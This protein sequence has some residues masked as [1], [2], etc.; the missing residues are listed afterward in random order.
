MLLHFAK[1]SPQEDRLGS[2]ID[3][4]FQVRF[5][6]W[7]SRTME[8]SLVKRCLILDRVSFDEFKILLSAHIY[9]CELEPNIFLHLACL[10]LLHFQFCQLERVQLKEMGS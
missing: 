5:F 6:L 2:L 3:L 8:V 7:L 4:V 9:V 1:V 10:I